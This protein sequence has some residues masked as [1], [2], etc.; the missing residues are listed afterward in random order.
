MK[1]I[2]CAFLALLL[3]FCTCLASGAPS[4][5]ACLMPGDK[6]YEVKAIQTVLKN[7]KYYGGEVDGIYDRATLEAVNAYLA[8][9]GFDAD[10]TVTREV[11]SLMGL[12]SADETTKQCM[13]KSDEKL[14]LTASSKGKVLA[15]LKAGGTYQLISSSKGW[16]KIRLNGVGVEGYVRTSKIVRTDSNKTV[17]V[18]PNRSMARGEQSADVVTLQKRL[19]ELGYYDYTPSGSYGSVTYMAIR[20]FQSH[21]S[22]ERT[23]VASIET[24]ELLFSDEAQPRDLVLE[25]NEISKDVCAPGESIQEQMADY[26]QTLL[27][28]PYILGAKGPKAYDCSGFTS[29]VFRDFGIEI[30]RSAYAQGHTS[31]V[32][33][34]IENIKDLQVGDMVFFN[35]NPNDGDECDHVGIFVGENRFVHASFAEGEI[36]VSDITKHYWKKIFSWGRR[37]EM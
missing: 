33:K 24:L 17:L 28:I 11:L 23:G 16:S 18:A 6:G 7:K 13:L 2:I 12:Y 26:A 29:R 4:D 35:T 30:P 36:I 1:R 37:V 25:E 14:R 20:A 8:D 15:S 9:N 32:G 3:S 27:G 22:L 31:S 5:E 10:G 19:T 21:N 34:K